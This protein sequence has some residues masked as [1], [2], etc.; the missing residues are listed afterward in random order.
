MSDTKEP[1][2]DYVGLNDEPAAVPQASGGEHDPFAN[3]DGA[4]KLQ[5]VQIDV[6]LTELVRQ[7]VR[8]ELVKDVIRHI[9]RQE[10]LKDRAEAAVATKA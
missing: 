9:I 8:E 7:V 1:F 2:D 10:I 3:Y 4:P 6:A 5:A